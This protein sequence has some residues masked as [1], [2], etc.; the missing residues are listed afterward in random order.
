MP[1]EVEAGRGVLLDAAPPSGNALLSVIAIESPG[2]LLQTWHAHVGDD[3]PEKS[4]F[5]VL[6]GAES[7]GGSPVEDDPRT[8]HPVT[9]PASLTDV[10]AETSTDLPRW[11]AEERSI[12]CCFRSIALRLQYASSEAV[13]RFL[14]QFTRRVTEGGGVAHSRVDPSAHDERS[15]DTP[16]TPSPARRPPVS[17]LPG[18]RRLR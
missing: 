3:P 16:P 8:I 9:H 17:I 5:L 4:A 6:D 2:D 14:H 12:G 18:A 11:D 15:V 10:G 7:A 13:Y 1:G